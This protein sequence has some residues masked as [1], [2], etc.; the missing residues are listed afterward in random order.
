VPD[1]SGSNASQCSL[2]PAIPDDIIV[3]VTV[4]KTGGGGA[5]NAS[6]T[7]FEMG[8]ANPARGEPN[9]EVCFAMTPPTAQ[10]VSCP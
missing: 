6:S 7:P 10:Q 1:P 9:K 3:Q 4:E 8:P 2:T 5:Y